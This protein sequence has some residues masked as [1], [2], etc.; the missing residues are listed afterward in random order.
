MDWKL[1]AFLVSQGDEITNDVAISILNCS[2][3]TNL[4]NLC[5]V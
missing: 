1:W 3:G 5:I 4:L 2:P